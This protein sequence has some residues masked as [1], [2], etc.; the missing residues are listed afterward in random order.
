MEDNEDSDNNEDS[1]EFVKEST[2][3]WM[4]MKIK[5]AT[6][7]PAVFEVKVCGFRSSNERQKK[8]T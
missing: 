5:K 6:V 1:I 3:L 4:P 2:G 8:T 7:E